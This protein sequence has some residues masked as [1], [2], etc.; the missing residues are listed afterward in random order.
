MTVGLTHHTVKGPRGF[1]ELLKIYAFTF[2]QILVS[3]KTRGEL[4]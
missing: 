2:A 3:I 1:T 4:N